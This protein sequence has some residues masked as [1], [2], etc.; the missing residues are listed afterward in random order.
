[1]ATREHD[2]HDE[3]VGGQVGH[4]DDEQV[5]TPPEAS[6]G[7]RPSGGQVSEVSAMSPEGGA[8]DTPGTDDG[9]PPADA[10]QTEADGPPRDYDA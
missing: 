1:M 5:N 4:P 7:G 2:E 9:V 3:Q 8:G 6:S 10:S